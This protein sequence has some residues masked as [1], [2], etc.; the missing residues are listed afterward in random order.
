VASENTSTFENNDVGRNVP[1][2]IFLK[3][4]LACEAQVVFKYFRRWA[5]SQFVY[6]SVPL[7]SHWRFWRRCAGPRR[8]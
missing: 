3:A 1:L 8:G 5:L 4:M 7:S 6:H 2:D